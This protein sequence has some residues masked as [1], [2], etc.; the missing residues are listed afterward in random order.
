MLAESCD[1]NTQA[2]GMAYLN[3]GWGLGNVLGKVLPMW[4]SH[5]SFNGSASVPKCV[6]GFT[7][8]MIGGFL[9]QPCDQYPGF[10]L[11]NNGTGLFAKL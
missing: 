4:S 9:S 8:P 6:G 1:A 7:G 3:L 5:L 11:C 2:A 10:P